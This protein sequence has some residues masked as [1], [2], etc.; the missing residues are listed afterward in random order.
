MAIYQVLQ[1]T[2]KE[3]EHGNLLCT[4][5]HWK[6]AGRWQLTGYCNPLVRSRDMATYR[7]LQSTGKEQED[8]NL[9]G[10]AIHW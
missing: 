3:H 5:I 6:R 1:S 9:P 7:V 8:G 4:A 10:I 2:G